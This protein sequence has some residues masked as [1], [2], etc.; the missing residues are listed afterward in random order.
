MRR[1][2]FGS[3]GPVVAALF[4]LVTGIALMAG[5]PRDTRLPDAARGS[6]V[7][8]A[9]QG[10]IPECPFH[11]VRNPDFPPPDAIAPIA[12]MPEAHDCQEFAIGNEYQ[13]RPFALYSRY[14]QAGVWGTLQSLAQSLPS[15][16]TTVAVLGAVVWNLGDTPYLPLQIVSG[17]NCVYLFSVRKGGVN[18]LKGWITPHSNCPLRLVVPE[19]NGHEL[20]VDRESGEKTYPVAASWHRDPR[21]SR[22]DYLIGFYCDGWCVLGPP[23]FEKPPDHSTTS[24]PEARRVFGTKGWYDQQELAVPHPVDPQRVVP[25]PIR[26]T[27]FPDSAL[28]RYNLADFQGAWREVA[29]VAFPAAH[30]RYAKKL[31]FK[32][33][34]VTHP[35]DRARLNVLS[36]CKGTRNECPGVPAEVR[37][38]WDNG[39]PPGVVGG[40]RGWWARIVAMSP[41]GPPADSTLYKCVVR[42]QHPEVPGRPVPATVR[43]R[44]KPTDETIWVRC[45]QGCCEVDQ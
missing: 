30:P 33:R 24:D 18:S 22:R 1:L 15:D 41:Q 28:G 5:S 40:D 27:A 10:G 32:N 43:F 34:P 12:D 38:S 17:Y 23:G 13:P 8:A 25:S 7:D 14:E 35:A 45:S 29:R 20:T 11:R 19:P 36:L 21:P 4:V 39:F 6:S 44:W 2:T 42:R 16:D 31:G 26:G 3:Q 9:R 37:C